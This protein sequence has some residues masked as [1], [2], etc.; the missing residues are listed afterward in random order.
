MTVHGSSGM[1][2]KYR[3]RLVAHLL[4]L[5]DAPNTTLLDPVQAIGVGVTAARHMLFDKAVRLQH[6]DPRTAMECAALVNRIDALIRLKV[7]P[8]LALRISV[9]TIG[10]GSCPG[11]A[12]SC[13]SPP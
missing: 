2:T 7:S 3:S 9:L 11:R 8:D 1:D 5:K 6:T 4:A 12:R 13:P 10:E